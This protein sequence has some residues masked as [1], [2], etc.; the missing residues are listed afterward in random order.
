[1]ETETGNMHVMYPMSIPRWAETSM[2][3]GGASVHS[4]Q[5][6]EALKAEWEE[7]QAMQKVGSPEG[8]GANRSINQGAGNPGDPGTGL[9][10]ARALD[11]MHLPFPQRNVSQR[12]KSL[13][14]AWG[15]AML[16][17]GWTGQQAFKRGEWW[18]Q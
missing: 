3:G 7:N 13:S 11:V 4:V 9:A 18:L 12:R 5:G 10:K 16:N 14:G 6:R 2:L 15:E 8:P 17:K 1:M